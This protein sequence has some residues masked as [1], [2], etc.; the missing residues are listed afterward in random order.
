MNKD[1]LNYRIRNFNIIDYNKIINLWK[2][3]DLPFKPNGRDRKNNIEN[4]LKTGNAIFF[5][6]EFNEKII[7][8]VFGA[9]DGRKG[10]INRLAIDPEFRRYD[11]ARKLVEKVEHQLSI[12]GIDI[13]CA[14]V[15][16]WNIDSMKFF[17]KL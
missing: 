17:K 9:H 3:A 15:E 7:G 10:W 6:A 12:L 5:I 11:I 8:S 13:V 4:E 2:K 16:D 14:L 1:K